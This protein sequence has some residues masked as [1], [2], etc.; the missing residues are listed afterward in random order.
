M[1]VT[2]YGQLPPD[3]QTWSCHG[4]PGSDKRITRD[5]QE[6]CFPIPGTRN[7]RVVYRHTDRSMCEH[8]KE[9]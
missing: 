6:G 2:I 4:C 3:D 8:I 7:L 9:Q 5:F 1:I